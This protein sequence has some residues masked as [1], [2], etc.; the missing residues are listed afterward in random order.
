MKILKSVL[1]L[2]ISLLFIFLIIPYIIAPVYR[3]SDSLPFSGDGFYNPYENWN[4]QNHYKANFHCH[5]NTWSFIADG[6]S[7]DNS[8]E[9]ILKQYQSYHYD[10]TGISNYMSI[11]PGSQIPLYEHGWGIRKM[12][13]LVAGS[14]GVMWLDFIYPF[15]ISQKQF[16]LNRL[17]TEDQ[18]IMLAHPGWNNAYT[19]G[20]VKLLG[21]YDCMEVLS[22][23]RESLALW[24][25]ALSAG[26]PVFMTVN[27]DGHD[28]MNP[29]VTGRIFNIIAA[30]N[31]TAA[32]I[33]KAMQTGCCV[34]Y[35]IPHTSD[36]AALLQFHESLIIPGEIRLHSDTLFIAFP[37]NLKSMILKGQGGRELLQVADTSALLYPLQ[38]GDTYV[39]C[40]AYMYNGTRIFLNPVIRGEYKKNVFTGEINT[41]MTLLQSV[42]MSLFGA[43]V[44]F[45]IWRKRK[46]RK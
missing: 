26:K 32:R 19:P 8:P 41:G 9:N 11:E 13:Q 45:L 40:E 31:T 42:L 2:F 4:R 3:F 43:S 15:H 21:N 35:E 20:D 6:G 38:P 28:V 30:E 24:D 17:K 37:E 10:V 12:H 27:D 25:S 22:T 36:T 39:R 14:E 16:I 46:K 44:L 7:R 1:K 5:S 23:N 18:L 33:I 29:E 34:G